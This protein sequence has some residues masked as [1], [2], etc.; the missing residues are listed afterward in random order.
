MYQRKIEFL[1]FG[2]VSRFQKTMQRVTLWQSVTNALWYVIVNSVIWGYQGLCIHKLGIMP[3]YK[4]WNSHLPYFAPIWSYSDFVGIFKSTW[5][6]TGTDQ[7]PRRTGPWDVF[8]SWSTLGV[9]FHRQ[10]F[11]WR[12]QSMTLLHWVSN[13]II[14]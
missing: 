2:T 14:R 9:R 3:R 13:K 12:S 11:N 6:R 5:M 1:C 10:R 7:N 4:I 8:N